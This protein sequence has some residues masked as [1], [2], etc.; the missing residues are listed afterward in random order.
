MYFEYREN[1][2]LLKIMFIISFQGDS[3][4]YII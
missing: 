3:T 4:P 2:E 1:K